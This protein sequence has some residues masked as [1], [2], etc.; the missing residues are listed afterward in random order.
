VAKQAKNRKS[1]GMIVGESQDG[2]LGI[3][4]A[5]V[6]GLGMAEFDESGVLLAL[7]QG[8]ERL[9]GCRTSSLKKKKHPLF[10]EQERFLK[11]LGEARESGKPVEASFTAFRRKEK[12]HLRGHILARSTPNGEPCFVV[13]LQDETPQHRAA[14]DLEELRE[15]VRRNMRQ[16]EKEAEFLR[17]LLRHTNETIQ[18]AVAVQDLQSGMVAYVNEAFEEITGLERINVL[19]MTFNEI[20]QEFPRTRELISDY[21][22]R[23]ARSADEDVETPPPAHMQVRLR[24]GEKR[25]EVYGRPIIVEAHEN[26]YILLIMEDNTERQRLQTQLVQSEKLAAVGQLAAGI[27][28]E[29]R[30][31]LNTIYN[32]LYD[33]EEILEEPSEDAQEDISISMEEIKRVQDIITNLLDFARESE[34]SSGRSNVNDV[35][36]K[37]VRLVQHDLSNKSVVITCALARIPEVTI[38]NNALKQILINLITNAAQA[39]E[40]G[41]E[42]ELRTK[43]GQGPVPGQDAPQA[44]QRE[45]RYQSDSPQLRLAGKQGEDDWMETEESVSQHVVLEISDDGPGIPP[46]VLPNIFNPFYTT[47]PPGS[48]TGL[49]LSVVHSLISDA[50]GAISVTSERGVGTTFL[51]ELPAVADEE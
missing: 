40:G 43:R 14:A 35:V 50:G 18:I 4:M 51:I 49:G 21:L 29:I 31:P 7:N 6:S 48:G 1:S 28:H 5:E 38:N 37:T 17:E 23:I 26:Q 11:A 22:K 2:A 15:R 30:N 39:M 9:F 41:G 12:L 13:L 19:G 47:K 27:A 32:A 46:D 36:N 20:F 33:L 24:S 3:L 42:I 25:L 44:S 34:R 10:M 8:A 45:K 16:T